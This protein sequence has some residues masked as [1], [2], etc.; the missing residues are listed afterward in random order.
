LPPGH[1]VVVITGSTG[2][3][4]LAVAREAM[5]RGKDVV[6][7]GRTSDKLDAVVAE[8]SGGP[9]RVVG[10][11]GDL[12]VPERVD[13]LV[14]TAI[15]RFGRVDLW[16]NNA[17]AVF[18]APAERIS[19]NGFATIMQT[20][21]DAAFHCCRAVLPVMREQGEGAVLNI[22]SIAAYVPH[23]GAAHYAASKAALNSLTQTLAVEWAPY[24][25]QVNGIALGP[26][27]TAA[28]RFSDAAQRSAMEARIPAGRVPEA[29]E[30]ATIVLDLAAITSTYFTGETVRVDGGFR[31]VMGSPA[32]E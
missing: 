1:K 18:F 29:S 30:V 24:G 14:A 11:A 15:D 21:V 5:A 9:G 8:L 4:G 27:L 2:G 23:P 31:S 3:I 7:N 10:S 17:A 16:I 19:P 12:R 13:A 20:N 6:L 25:I 22:S 26:V 28:S 32:G